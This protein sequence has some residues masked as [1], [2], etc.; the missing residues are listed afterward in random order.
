[1]R[2]RTLAAALLTLVALTA[3]TAATAVAAGPTIGWKQVNP[4]AD[5]AARAGLQAVEVGGRF[6]V[7]GGRTPTD[8]AIV[9]IPGASTI[10]GD[11]WSSADRGR[12]WQRQTDSAWPARA[13]FQ[14]V[15]KDGKMFV[16]G[17]QDFAIIPNPAC[18]IFPPGACPPAIP[19]FVAKSQFFNDVWRSTNGRDWTQVTDHAPWQGRAG[20]SA[21]VSGDWIYVMGGSKNDD[22]AIVGPNGPARLY[23]NDVWRSKDGKTWQA[24]TDKAGWAPRAGAAV[25]VKD[26]W[27]YILGGED[28]FV[29]NPT[30]PRCPP[31]FNDVWRSRD[32]AHWSQVTPAAGWSAR[33]GHQCV[34]AAGQIVCFGGF[35]VPTN[36]TD[37]Y[38]SPNGRDWVKL[39]STA[40]GATSPDQIKYDFDALVSAGP[41][42]LPSIYTFGGDRE[43]FDFGNPTNYLRVDNDVWRFGITWTC[44][45]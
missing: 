11:V 9:P 44:A 29:C 27:I 45:S 37:M 16:L 36:P 6:F 30:T 26:G 41:L 15:T 39:R 33:P 17:G 38:A 19:P 12:S 14:A 23:F 13:Y 7:M 22:S 25:V 31:Y 18:A 35:G 28:G 20:L 40:W 1:M 42:G 34:V 5:W 10:W 4:H 8:P 3:G 32:G 43:T 2:R 24:M 21:V